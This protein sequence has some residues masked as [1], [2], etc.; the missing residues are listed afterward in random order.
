MAIE[1]GGGSDTNGA[2]T[3][4]EYILC[5]SRTNDKSALSKISIEAEE[6]DEEDEKG[7]SGEAEN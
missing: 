5:Y 3:D 7:N 4:H 6:L 1:K 2:V